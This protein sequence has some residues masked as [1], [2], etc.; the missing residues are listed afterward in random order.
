MPQAPND[1]RVPAYLRKLERRIG[2]LKNAYEGY[3]WGIPDLFAAAIQAEAS[4]V[5]QERQYERAV[6]VRR[7]ADAGVDR[8]TLAQIRLIWT[9]YHFTQAAEPQRE[10]MEA[11]ACLR[12]ELARGDHPWDQRPP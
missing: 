1:D 8:L 10:A 11:L 6:M 4:I 7:L 2:P 3:L 9:E 12:A 5:A